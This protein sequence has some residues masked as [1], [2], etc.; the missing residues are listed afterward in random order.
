MADRYQR[1]TIYAEGTDQNEILNGTNG[2]DVLYGN[3]G[4]DRIRG[5]K[6]DDEIEGGRGDDVII[7]N[8]GEDW[9]IG[10]A[11]NDRLDGG[12]GDEAA[13]RPAGSARDGGGVDD[14]TSARDTLRFMPSRGPLNS[15]VSDAGGDGQPHRA[16]RHSD[17]TRPRA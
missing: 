12:N 8:E 6:G 14:A 11:G 3:A 4:D 15:D 5:Y 7:G 9:L 16:V 17:A 10:D 2:H 1:T 13:G